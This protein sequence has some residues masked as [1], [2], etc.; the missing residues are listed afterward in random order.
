MGDAM[1]WSAPGYTE[2]KQLGSGVSG[3]VVLA[4]H[5]ETGVKVAVK[6]LSER[7]LRDPVALSR[8]QSEARLLTTLRDQNIATMW[9]YI[10]TRDGAAIVMEL[11]NGVSL[12]ALLRENGTTGP[13]AA[14]VVLKGSLLGLAR[15]HRA[16]VVHKDYKPENVVVRDDGVSKL[17]DFGVAVRQGTITHPEGTPPYMA[18]EL[19]EGRPASPA[20]DVY[21][22]TV[23]FFECL[24]GHRPY[25]STEP[26]V[27]GYQHKHA[28]IPVHDAPG[29]VRALILRGLAKDPAA[30]PAGAD[31]FV[32]ELEETARAAFGEDWEERGKRR[33]VAL[34]AL[35]ALLLPVPQTPP[36]EVSTS[37][38]R[39]VF[40]RVRRRRSS[41]HSAGRSVS[42]S[43]GR[44]VGRSVGRAVRHHAVRMAMGVTLAAAVA[45]AAVVALSS[46]ERAATPFDVAAA[47]PP[48]SQAPA[49]L[50][51][52]PPETPSDMA[53]PEE[54]PSAEPSAVAPP[55]RTRRQSVVPPP[56]TRTPKPTV[57]PAVTRT[58]TRSATPKPTP[59]ATPKATPKPTPKATPKVT[60]KPTPKVTPTVTPTITQTVTPT[61][62]T[63][64]SALSVGGLA[65]DG[66]SVASGTFSVRATGTAPIT[67]TATWAV[68]GDTVATRRLRLG[69]AQAYTRTLTHAFGER[70]CGQDVTLTVTTTP[71]APG[72]A[73]TATTAVP[74][75]PTEVSGLRVALRMDAPPDADALA[76]VGVVTSGTGAVPVEVSF[77]VNGDEV[78]TRSATLSGRTS[79]SRQFSQGFKT[80]PCGATVSVVVRA[81]DRQATART[82]VSCPPGVKRITVTRAS[83]SPR[84]VASAVISV[85]TD[86]EQPVRLNVSFS[87][88]G[89]IAGTE[90]FELSGRTEYSQ[91][92][93][94]TFGELPCGTSWLVEAA[95]RPQADNGGDKGGGR[96][97]D[98]QSEEP[99]TPAPETP[100]TID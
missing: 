62:I 28:P 41:S 81:G 55:T 49:E 37:L 27:L 86:N 83:L 33:L 89:R 87:V 74:P 29:A 99:K 72:G 80:R 4:V 94:H 8:F 50:A 48:T 59:K 6:Y 35:L 11:V 24:T 70:P 58:P 46:R 9:E 76:Q 19:W 40:R 95:S 12:R 75:C 20:T 51:S 65:V 91:V 66:D 79:Y 34:V 44:S 96:T 32:R 97:P 10:Q 78:G 67:A 93:S 39:T 43:M 3:R 16:G 88:G 26:S 69:G 73:R 71:A 38:G 22:A 42:R 82:E 25:R 47:G 90:T 17:V 21:A 15:A 30:R 52:P 56:A 54:S 31:A 13:E 63:S 23:T 53:S 77:R 7:M 92:V 100:G 84:G 14:L 85:T 45:I 5:D 68:A 98:C 1:E 61:P 64:V 2:V 57:T 18:P 36:A 60:P